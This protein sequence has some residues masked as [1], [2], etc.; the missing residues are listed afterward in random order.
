MVGLLIGLV[1]TGLLPIATVEAYDHWIAFALLV[2]VGARMAWLAYAGGDEDE[3]EREAPKR[4]SSFTLAVTAIAT[5]ID[6][7]A[8]GV[9]LNYM[10][11][12]L[13]LTI[14]LI[15]LVT[16]AMSFGGV[17][18]GRMAGPLL[19]R[20]AEVAGGF[21]LIAIGAKILIEHTM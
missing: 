11:V 19:G 7:T 4:H 17:M 13:P 3:E 9:T 5:S 16:F 6:A 14:A 21:C 8:V 2:A 15:G 20:W 10:N 1:F 18:I 12:N